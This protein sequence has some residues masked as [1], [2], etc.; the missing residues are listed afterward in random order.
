LFCENDALVSPKNSLARLK[1]LFG[2]CPPSEIVTFTI[3][4]ANHGFKLS[5]KCYDGPNQK[6]QFAQQGKSMIRRWIQSTVL[7]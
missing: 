4:G 7:R 3:K 2:M 5:D 6:L 1:E